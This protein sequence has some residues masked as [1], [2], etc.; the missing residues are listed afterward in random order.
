MEDDGMEMP[1]QP[2]SFSLWNLIIRPPRRRYHLSRLGPEEFNLWSCGVRRIDIDL[3]S[4]RGHTLRCSHF[5]PEAFGT[6]ATSPVPCVIYL[7]RNASC[8][9]EALQMVPLFLPLGISLFCLDFAGCGESGGDYISL[10]WFE[11]DDL[12]ECVNYLRGTGRVSAIG[13]WGRSMGAVTA[14]L[15]ADRDHSIGGMVLDSPFC[16]LRQLAGE[17]AQSEYLSVKVPNWLLSG[18]LAMGRLRI[19]S[20]CD[21]D[22][23]LLAPEEHVGNSFIP[24]L[25]LHGNADDFIAPHHSQTLFEAYTGD[26]ELEIVEGDHNSQRD[27]KVIRKAVYFFVRALRCPAANTRKQNM[28]EVLGFDS[29][30]VDMA[31]DRRL[32]RGQVLFEAAWHLALSGSGSRQPKPKLGEVQ[33]CPLPVRIEGALHLQSADAEAGYCVGLLPM[34]GDFGVN[35]PPLVMFGLVSTQGLQILRVAEGREPEV[36]ARAEIQI[37]PGVPVLCVLEVKL[38]SVQSPS[39][40]GPVQTP[41]LRLS[42]GSGESPIVVTLAEEFEEEFFLW[43]ATR[44][45]TAE[46]FETSI[47]E[48]AHNEVQDAG[49]RGDQQDVAAAARSGGS[50]NP[51]TDE[52]SS[53]LGC[54]QS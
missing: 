53:G 31:V 14:L 36:L 42:L 21:F 40:F 46:F 34:P 1:G 3:T 35:R 22:I 52:S 47:R 9:L 50:G 15:H 5:L 6:S 51:S 26:K 19:K 23:D 25:F 16:N 33:R 49:A 18:A 54:R 44:R 39:Y 45:G 17:L 38:P 37:E 28:A 27:L 11:R 20:L 8:R 4:P 30:E 24:A 10:G 2:Y 43:S 41:S 32:L 12:A 7:H 29:L 13:L 48:T